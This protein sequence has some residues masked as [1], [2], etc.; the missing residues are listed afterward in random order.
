M[1]VLNNIQAPDNAPTDKST[2]DQ[3]VPHSR[4]VVD[5][6]NAAIYW[7]AK[8]GYGQ[9]RA[10]SDW[11]PASGVFM[12]PGSRRLPVPGPLYGVRFWAA[13]PTANLPTGASQAR[14]TVTMV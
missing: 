1:D 8:L 9:S 13:V 12:T 4:A 3:T 2:I 5:V 7:Q 6:Q 10:T 14:V 11:L